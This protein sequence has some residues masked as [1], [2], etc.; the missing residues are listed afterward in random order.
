MHCQRQTLGMVLLN[1]PLQLHMQH[2]IPLPAACMAAQECSSVQSRLL[3]LQQLA[4]VC[5]VKPCSMRLLCM[6]C[7]PYAT[8]R[9]SSLMQCSSDCAC[10]PTRSILV[11][12]TD[13]ARSPSTPGPV[14]CADSLELNKLLQPSICP[15]RK[16]IVQ[17]HGRDCSPP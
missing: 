10:A 2:C 17:H 16:L 14:C 1:K 9:L 7:N 15:A 11:H 8:F 4:L 6:L 12:W 5:C 13:A 3:N